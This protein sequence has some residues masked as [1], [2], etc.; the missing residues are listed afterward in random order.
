MSIQNY[1]VANPLLILNDVG[2]AIDGK[3]I[4]RN[5]GTASL[6]FQI[7]DIQKTNVQQGQII[8]VLGRSG[9]G[10]TTLFKALAGIVPISH[11]S[12]KIADATNTIQV[13]EIQEGD[14]G[15]VQQVYPLS[16]NQTVVEMLTDAAQQG[17]YS[18]TDAKNLIEKYLQEWGLIDQKNLSPN[19]L[20]GGQR[21]RV[22]II[23][24]LL[25]NHTYMIFDEPFS[26]LDVVNIQGVKESFEKINT[27]NDINTILFSTHDIE[28]AVELADHIFIIGYEKNEK[29]EFIPGGTLVGSYDLKKLGLAWQPFSAAHQDLANTIKQQLAVS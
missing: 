8:A 6:P 3:T 21:Q 15:F 11:G 13:K 20:S 29:N 14:M 24:Q 10:K 26:G 9:R 28:I 25:C 22:A 19:Q 2:V 27:S 7:D 5:V 17:S 16:R 12:I 18:N 1:T 23:E 4:L